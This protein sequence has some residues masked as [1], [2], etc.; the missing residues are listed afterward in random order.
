[1]ETIFDVLLHVVRNVPFSPQDR[2]IAE[3]LL[4]EHFN[5]PDKTADELADEAAQRQAAQAASTPE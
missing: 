2:A 4:R 5:V 1:M 3:Q